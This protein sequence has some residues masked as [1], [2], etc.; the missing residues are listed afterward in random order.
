MGECDSHDNFG[1]R[2][3]TALDVSLGKWITPSVGVRGQYSGLQVL[4]CSAGKS[5]YSEAF[6]TKGWYEEKFRTMNLHADF[7]WNISNAI[8]GYKED[9]FWDLI[10]YA[11]F[12]WGRSWNKESHVNEIVTNVGLLNN[13]RLTS[14][15][16]LNIEAKLMIV[17]ERFDQVAY[18]DP[19]EGLVSLTAGLT[20][21]FPVRTFKRASDIAFVDNS[22]QY[23][24]QINDLKDQLAKA[25]AAR[26]AAAQELAA[27]KAKE[28]KVII[29]KY[30]VLNDWA[31][32]FD[33][34]KSNLTEKEMIN[35]GYIAETI[36]QC[37]DKKFVIFASADKGTGS[38]AYNNKLK[39]KRASA[40]CDA[41]T[42]KYGVNPDQLIIKVAA[43]DEEPFNTP[44]T[45]RVVIVE[46]E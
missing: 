26:D 5:A 6:E 25:Q 19:F 29:E 37:P 3:G 40:V 18:A 46:C 38:V 1:R 28:P 17:N 13:L 16:D 9:R 36:K 22:A 24:G 39:A 4:G 42:Q 11:G 31:V 43:P 7:L 30:P 32:F 12:G 35:L 27:E 20:Y 8:S 45:N 15:L 33:I 10:P 34:N 14:W 23:L 44:K 41:L 2:I 21:N